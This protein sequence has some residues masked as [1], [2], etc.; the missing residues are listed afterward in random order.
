MV[1]ATFSFRHRMSL[2]FWLQCSIFQVGTLRLGG[3]V[4]A[5]HSSGTLQSPHRLPEALPVAPTPAT[6]GHICR[7]PRFPRGGSQQRLWAVAIRRQAHFLGH[8]GRLQKPTQT[9][10]TQA[11]RGSSHR[12]Q[13]SLATL[14]AQPP[15]LPS[16][17]GQT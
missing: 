5:G 16:A 9:Q 7:K 15:L 12:R 4:G 2:R 13:V 11:P 6:H 8:T 3:S 14:L 10:E 17:Q 1:T